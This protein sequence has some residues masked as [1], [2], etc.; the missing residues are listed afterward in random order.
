[1][2]GSFVI[3]ESRVRSIEKGDW[4]IFQLLHDGT[5]HNNGA[6][7][8]VRS[9]MEDPTNIFSIHLPFIK[10]MGDAIDFV[11]SYFRIIGHNAT[12]IRNPDG[13]ESVAYD[14]VFRVVDFSQ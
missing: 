4:L 1:M 14:V 7:M 5:G 13:W 8:S 9:D 12:I 3:K 11:Y 10:D 6:L 2:D